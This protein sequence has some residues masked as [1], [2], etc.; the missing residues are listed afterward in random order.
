MDQ[1]V[2]ARAPLR[3]PLGGGGTDLPSHYRAHGGFAVSATIDRH[4]HVMLSTALARRF[5]LKHLEWEDVERPEEIR[6]PILHAAVE[7]HWDR[8]PFELASVGDV[9][10]GTGL[11]S[12]S[13]YTVGV[14][15]ALAT[16]RGEQLSPEGLAARACRLEIE[17]LS[18]SVGVRDQYAIAVGGVTAVTLAAGKPKAGAGPADDDWGDDIAVRRLDVSDATLA[19]LRDRFLLFFAGERQKTSE[20]MLSPL[21]EG[22]DD[23]AMR[24][25][26]LRTAEIAR[27]VAA[28]LEAGDLATVGGLMDEQWALKV[29]R[30]PNAIT[31]RIAQLH[32]VA[33]ERGRAGGAVLGGAGGGGFLLVYSED[34]E[35]TR[36]A[37]SAVDA[38]ELR[39]SVELRGCSAGPA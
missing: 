23:A 38:P 10:P 3:I 2:V 25:N 4:V 20:S 18:Q 5:R 37:M 8:T 26:L 11:G 31:E 22:G 24:R 14:L 33:L 21:I 19:G 39:F 36:T 7:R 16:A 1:A 15:R 17:Q 35:A 6:H 13:A 34:P 27:E 30:T 32:A 29:E 28:A 9:P 12:S